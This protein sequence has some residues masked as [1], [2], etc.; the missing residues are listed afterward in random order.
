LRIGEAFDSGTVTRL[1]ASAI[2][3]IQNTVSQEVECKS[4]EL[5]RILTI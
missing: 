5:C 1:W 2:K 4:A 3:L